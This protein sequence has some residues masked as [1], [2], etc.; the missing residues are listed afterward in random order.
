MVG[1]VPGEHVGQARLDPDADQG[2]PAGVLP[3]L[4]AGELL[5]A[6]LDPALGVG[7]LGVGPGQ[8]HRHVQVVGPCRQ[9]SFEHGHHEPRVDGV[10]H[11]GDAVAAG[12][13]SHGA[14]VGGVDGGGHQ[15]RVTG[16]VHG[17]FGPGEV[18]VGEDQM[19]EEVA[20]GGDPGHRRPHPT[21]TNHQHPH[22]TSTV[23]SRNLA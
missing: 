2:Q 17:G 7:A 12:Q 16:R 9:R 23:S 8:A 5:V 14:G 3:G 13:P 22:R 19:L 4:L 10:E 15:P 6:E 11:M 21:G 18:V 20:T 1:G